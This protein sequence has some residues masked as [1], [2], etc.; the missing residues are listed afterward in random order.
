M[1]ITTKTVTT[2]K[3]RQ[4]VS[5]FSSEHVEGAEYING[6]Y[7]IGSYS[8]GSKNGETHITGKNP[9]QVNDG[10]AAITEIV[11]RAGLDT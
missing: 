9:D 3:G 11:R 4:V 7:L 10:D 1:D 8:T 2:A 6:K 5:V